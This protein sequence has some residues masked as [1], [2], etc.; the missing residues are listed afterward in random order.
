MKS[1]ILLLAIIPG[2]VF[3]QTHLRNQKFIDFS[4]G[5]YDGFS[6]KNYSLKLGTGQYD[7]KSSVNGIEFIIARKI[8]PTEK[9]FIQVPVEQLFVSYKREYTLFKNYNKTFIFSLSTK[10]NLG[11]EFINRNKNN[12][13]N[14]VLASNSDYLL[15]LG[16]GPNVEIYNL[17]LGVI[18]NFNFISQY[19]KLSTFPYLKYRFH[20]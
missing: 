5:G 1:I 8:A 16:F 6:P 18:G 17:H 12:G 13:Q 7:K 4:L 2:M 20:L 15:G 19:Q 11:Y 3:S 10:A 9:R 14:Y